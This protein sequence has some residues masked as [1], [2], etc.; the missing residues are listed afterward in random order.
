[1]KSCSVCLREKEEKKL[2]RVN[3]KLWEK[4]IYVCNI[5]SKDIDAQIN[6]H[7]FWTNP[8]LEQLKYYRDNI[9]LNID[10]MIEDGYLLKGAPQWKKDAH[11]CR[12][13]TLE[14][15]N[16]SIEDYIEERK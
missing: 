1:M 5:C 7:H 4:T 8:S 3:L 2:A 15:A 10:R 13:I 14:W 6:G 16:K 9:Q 11:S 12:L